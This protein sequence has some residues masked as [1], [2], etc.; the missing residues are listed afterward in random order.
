MDLDFFSN[1]MITAHL[2]EVGK[3]RGINNIHYVLYKTRKNRFKLFGGDGVKG[4]GGRIKQLDDF[5]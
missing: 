5:V 2:R 1:V 3:Q 4:A